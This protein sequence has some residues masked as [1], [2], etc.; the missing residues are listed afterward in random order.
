MLARGSR[1][2]LAVWEDAKMQKGIGDALKRGELLICDGAMGTMLQAQGIP[3]GMLSE[4]WNEQRPD[5]I[6][7]IHRAY[8]DAGAQIITT[9]TFN[10]NRV[11]MGEAGLAGRSAELTRLGVALAREAV[12]NKAWIAGDVGP[13]GQLL[14]PYGSLT[15]AQAE[16]AYAEQAI[17]LAEA[18]ADLILIE[19]MTDI[20]EA[21]CAVRAAKAHTVLPV[22]CTFAFNAKGRT[23]MGLRPDVAAVRVQE[24]GGDAVGANCGEGP[25]AIIA[26]LQG[27]QGATGLPLI[28]Q[29]NAGVPRWEKDSQSVWDVGPEQMAEH[30]RRFV[31]LGARIVGG[32]CGSGPAHIAAIAA[33][34]RA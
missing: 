29:S 27:M 2:Q 4:L 3:A 30:A 33:A 1:K 12:G 16:E 7:G 32:C 23:M 25:E 24:V 5:V 19:T 10:G 20:E 6:L 26:A 21:C 31:S 9:N 14:E 13:T 17:A 28:A 15:A 22:F 8:L 11:R 34:L 18:G